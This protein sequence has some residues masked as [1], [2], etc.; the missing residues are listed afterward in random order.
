MTA[1]KENWR[2]LAEA[3]LRGRS[4]DD[5]TWHTLEGIDV[6]PLVVLSYRFF[7]ELH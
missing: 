2:N 5:L 1:D 3:E 7:Y 4:L 6:K